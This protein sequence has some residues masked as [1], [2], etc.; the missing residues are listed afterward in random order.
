[1]AGEGAGR[2]T[3]PPV[4][5][6]V[7]QTKDFKMGSVARKGVRGRF[8][9]CVATMELRGRMETDQEKMAKWQKNAGK[10]DA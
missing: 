8:V 7:W 6:E 4:F 1:M 9:G 5:A 10:G 3:P 2:G